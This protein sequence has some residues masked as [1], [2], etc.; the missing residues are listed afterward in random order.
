MSHVDS[1]SAALASNAATYGYTMKEGGI[2]NEHMNSAEIDISGY[3][4]GTYYF[5]MN[6]E[7]LNKVQNGGLK[8]YKN[9][10][11]FA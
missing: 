4:D 1:T 5:N 9:S 11:K 8:I 6:Q 10:I 7:E 2:G 3:A